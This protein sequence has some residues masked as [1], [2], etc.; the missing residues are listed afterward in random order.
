MSGSLRRIATAAAAVV[1]WMWARQRR[2]GLARDDRREGIVEAIDIDLWM[3]SNC[4]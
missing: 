2:R 3:T 1:S 4:V